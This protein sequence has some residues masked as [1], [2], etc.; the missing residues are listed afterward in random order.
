MTEDK[1]HED[2]E[3]ITGNVIAAESEVR[4]PASIKVKVTAVLEVTPAYLKDVENS[5][6]TVREAIDN[7]AVALDG[8]VLSVSI[9]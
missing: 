2:S 9:S 4:S 7:M 3:D 1:I 6:H 8:H 5:I